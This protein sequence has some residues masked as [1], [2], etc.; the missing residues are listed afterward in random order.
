[1][2]CVDDNIEKC[3]DNEPTLI[4][5]VLLQAFQ[6]LFDILVALHRRRLQLLLD[7]R[8]HFVGLLLD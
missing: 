3:T 6:H 4:T 2:K 8:S 5:Y 7:R 1:M